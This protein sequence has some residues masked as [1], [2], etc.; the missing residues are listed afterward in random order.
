MSRD[1][2]LAPTGVGQASCVPIGRLEAHPT[3]VAGGSNQR[4]VCP[5]RISVYCV[6]E[7]WALTSNPSI[8]DPDV[9]NI[10]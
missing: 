2:L 1:M 7:E 6:P 3:R 4:K 8:F 9:L 10:P 5:Q